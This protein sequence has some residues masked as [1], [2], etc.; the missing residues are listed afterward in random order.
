M[1]IKWIAA[2]TKFVNSGCIDNIQ[3]GDLKCRGCAIYHEV[4]SI[5]QLT[6]SMDSV[7]APIRT[8]TVA[9]GA[10]LY[11]EGR[12]GGSIYTVRRGLVKLI[13]HM[14]DGVV[15][16]VR[17]Q[18]PGDVVGLEALLGLAYEH[19]SIALDDFEFCC[20]P[21]RVVHRLE[22]LNPAMYRQLIVRWHR[23]LHQADMWITRFSTGPV[24]TRVLRLIHYLSAI[25]ADI[26][27]GKVHLLSR[28]D[29]AAI[30]GVTTESVSRVIAELKRTRVLIPI[31]ANHRDAYALDE[32]TFT[33]LDV[34]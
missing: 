7:L 6:G 25:E 31:T 29:M 23:C 22:Q 34:M 5:D 11:C 21:V 28:E 17:L 26:G 14:P 27:Q 13:Q 3:R 15:R 24:R 33:Q 18:C 20:I 8:E 1:G 4:D 32:G 10:T 12:M 30:L 16:I 2:N 19:T 9:P